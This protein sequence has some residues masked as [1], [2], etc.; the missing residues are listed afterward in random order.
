[1]QIHVQAVWDS[2]CCRK[3]DLGRFRRKVGRRK[4]TDAE[5]RRVIGSGW[6][7]RRTRQAAAGFT[8]R[9][10]AVQPPVKSL[11]GRFRLD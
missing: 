1:M 11:L 5:E 10:R 3:P 9:R 7:V 8:S 2:V 4:R 6:V